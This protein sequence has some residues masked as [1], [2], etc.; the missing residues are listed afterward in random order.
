MQQIT[1]SYNWNNKLDC[2]AFTTLR[3]RNDQR[4]QPGYQY[5]INLKGESKGIGEITSVKNFYLDQLN[6]F[7][8][9][10]DTGYDVAKCREIILRMYP[11]VDFN[12]TMLSLILIRK[13]DYR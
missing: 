6:P 4:Y 3:L 1:F 9:Y 11:K 12:R 13:I 10:L 5:E 7:I 8:A 2:T